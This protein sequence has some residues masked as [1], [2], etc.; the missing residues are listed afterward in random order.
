MQDFSSV[1]AVSVAD[2]IKDASFPVERRPLITQSGHHSTEYSIV[3]RIDEN[4]DLGLV[5]KT[6]PEIKHDSL[7][8]WLIQDFEDAGLDYKLRDSVVMSKGDLYQEYIFDR[9]VD[10]PDN[11][12]MAP[13]A[14][15]KASYVD[16]PLEVFFGTYRFVCS[17]G[18][19]VGETIN[20]IRVAPNTQNLLQS[21]IK[22]E[23]KTRLSEF[24]EVS[25]LYKK[26]EDES[27]NPYLD[28]YLAEVYLSAGYKKAVLHELEKNGNIEVLKDKL[29][30][31]DFQGDVSKLYNVLDEITAWEFY[32]IVTNILTM[33]ARSVGARSSVY[34]TASKIFGI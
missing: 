21:S 22:D 4:I 5:K 3:H 9:K 28:L 13:M 6:R 10:T 14:L 24:S 26:L 33:K 1:Q 29:R 8:K 23:I 30:N 27:F 2:A 32:N 17:N 11:S 25:N 19:I 15:V 34:H 20:K 12:D 7:I 18:V 16:V 31:P